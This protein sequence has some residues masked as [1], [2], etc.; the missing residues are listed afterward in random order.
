MKHGLTG[1]RIYKTWSNMKQRCHNPNASKYNSYGGKGITVCEEWRN[2]FKAFYNWSME[3]G[4][5]DNLTIDIIDSSKGYSPD[6][7]RWITIKENQEKI[8]GISKNSKGSRADYFKERR[9]KTRN[10]SVEVD[11]EKFDSLEEKLSKEEKTKTQWL[12]EKIE[13]ELNK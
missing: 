13:E 7:C 11:R 1:T 6:N 8:G 4:Y 10:F 5:N 2:N 3:N 12:N 9:K